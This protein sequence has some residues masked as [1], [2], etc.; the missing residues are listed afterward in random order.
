VLTGWSIHSTLARVFHLHKQWSR[1]EGLEAKMEEQGVRRSRVRV[2]RQVQVLRIDDVRSVLVEESHLRR[3]ALQL[4]HQLASFAARKL[5]GPPVI[6]RTKG[7][8]DGADRDSKNQNHRWRVPLWT[9]S[10]N[11]ELA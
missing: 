8:V 1:Q 9:V 7:S 2:E 11:G 10:K 5:T 6:H 4:I 3:A